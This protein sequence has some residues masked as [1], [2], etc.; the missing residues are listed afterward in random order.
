MWISWYGASRKASHFSRSFASLSLSPFLSLHPSSSYPLPVVFICGPLSW[1]PFVFENPSC[2]SLNQ[3]HTHVWINRHN[4]HE[5]R[6]V[7]FFI[8]QWSSCE[9]SLKFW[10]LI[11]DMRGFWLSPNFVH[12]RK[13]WIKTYLYFSGVIIKMS[14]Y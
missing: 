13:S 10:T 2:F 14:I 11:I 6:K 7:C 5:K 3:L 8:S 4:L 12:V 9:T 1:L